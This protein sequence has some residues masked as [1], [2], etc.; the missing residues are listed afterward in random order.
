MAQL[1]S[2]DADKTA[3]DLEE[4]IRRHV[5]YSL[6]KEPGGMSESD[7]MLA[8]SLA[9]RD[10]AVDLMLDTERRVQQAKAKRVYYLSAE[11]LIGRSLENN[12]INLGL[13]E[14]AQQVV[15]KLGF[16]IEEVYEEENDAA[17]GNGGLGRLAA[18]F[19]DSLA[20]LDMPGYGYGI[21]YE[22]GLFK[23]D[24][25]NGYQRERPDNWLRFGTPW[26]I[27]HPD[28]TYLIPVYGRAEHGA[29]FDGNYNP[30]W[31][32]WKLFVGVPYD[33]P[34][35][36]YGGR[37]V[38]YLRL[39]SARASSEFD[40]EIFN[41]GDYF[42]ALHDQILSETVTRVLY[43]SDLVA[44]GRELRLIQEYFLVACAIRDIV[45]RY[46]R[47]HDNFDDF[48]SQVAIQIND[49][50]PALA[51][52]ELMRMLVD[53]KHVPWDDAWRITQA[54]I[55]YTN[56]TLMSEALERWPV[57]LFERVLP[58]H[59]L[60]IYEINRRFLDQV[61]TVWPG[62]DGRRQR[63][64]IIEEEPEKKVRMANLA[65]VGSHSVNGVSEMHTELVK[66]D[67]VPD[68]YQLWPEK[69]NN[70]TNGVT[71]RRWLLAANPQLTQLITHTIGEGWATDTD[72]LHELE[73]H[74]QDPSVQ[75]E[76]LKLSQDNRNR[77]AKIIKRNSD[78]D[79]DPL[80]L[81]DV[82]VKR[83]HEY[84]RQLLSVMH[85]IHEYLSLV[86]DGQE[87]LVPRT[88][89]FAGKAASGYWAAKQIIKLI[90]SVGE[91]VNHDPKADGWMRVA[92]VPDYRVS[93][94]EKIIPA[95]DLNEQISMAGTEASGTG[96]MKFAMNGAL[97]MGTRDGAN[98]EIMQEVGEENIYVF[99]WRAEELEDMRARG[100]YDPWDYCRRYPYIARIMDAFNSNR[101]CPEEPG[102]FQWIYRSILEGG[103]PYFHL[104]DLPSYLDAHARAGAEFKQPQVWARKALLN[105]ARIGKFSS[106]R[107]IRQ[108]AG[109]I[110]GV[111]AVRG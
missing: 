66:S 109:E 20:T 81:F 72:R 111:G 39:Y 80:S 32:D 22:F 25:I 58:R 4:A 12:L 67:L 16:D 84:K 50:H 14:A 17:L 108:Y 60:I 54:T 75:D 29:D 15:S 19:L 47:D 1:H 53:Q 21:N 65:I 5:R 13:L 85:I 88:Y 7:V 97:I 74:V 3:A 35:V 83:I 107:T 92:F 105:V 69:F 104:A 31:L 91:V 26:E 71:P 34:I 30:M 63:M 8:L 45:S 33:M 49:T 42:N 43:P 55:G 70:K 51:V 95:A 94:A 28:E 87:P 46:L 40:T 27:A 24:I 38:N 56:H 98:I 37:T 102:L 73:A 11:F 110:W 76:F 100:A 99:G 10:R 61:R 9:T 101:F 36:G 64:S 68:F 79:A 23:Q 2:G 41:E 57:E 93:L 18:C 89:V 90:H 96:N 62:D 82:Q 59:L 86:E 48:A 77:L 6:G 78:V 44:H 106:D 103:D 52:V